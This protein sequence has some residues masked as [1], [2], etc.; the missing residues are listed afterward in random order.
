MGIMLFIIML[1]VSGCFG[2]ESEVETFNKVKGTIRVVYQ[3]KEAFYRDYG[4]LFKLKQPDIDVEVVS[5]SEL[6][7][8]FGDPEF[9]FE[10]ESQKLL[11]KY[12]PDVLLLDEASFRICPRREAVCN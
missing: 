10:K 5:K 9:D 1:L 6:Y 12:N 3:D 2:R 11:D 8:K 4:Q 7:S